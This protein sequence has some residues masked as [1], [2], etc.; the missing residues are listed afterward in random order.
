VLEA[1]QRIVWE[2][3]TWIQMGTE[4][5]EVRRGCPVELRTMPPWVMIGEIPLSVVVAR[6]LV[7][8]D[9]FDW[10]AFGLMRHAVG[11]ITAGWGACAA[12]VIEWFVPLERGAW[13]VKEASYTLGRPCAP[14]FVEELIGLILVN[15]V[16]AKGG[17]EADM[18][19]LDQ[20]RR[21][22]WE[23]PAALGAFAIG[24]VLT[25]RC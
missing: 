11:L 22:R 15:A 13:V 24:A 6:T 9:R 14:P 20:V 12:E 8:L 16:Y 4:G 10:L 1:Q 7:S 5:Q 3:S 21:V 19:V 23:G 17:L 2:G 18:M 25:G